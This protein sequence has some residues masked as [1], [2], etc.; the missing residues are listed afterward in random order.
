MNVI[1]LEFLAEN[2]VLKIS[3]YFFKKNE[4][5]LKS[6]FHVVISGSVKIRRS[7]N[8]PKFFGNLKRP[9]CITGVIPRSEPGPDGQ[10]ETDGQGW[11]RA[12]FN[13]D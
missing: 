9:F 8:F 10:V 3:W 6:P 4:D 13:F 2:F 7:G 12:K 1:F 11:T 5:C